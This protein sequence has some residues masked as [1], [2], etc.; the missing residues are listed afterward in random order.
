MR[1]TPIFTGKYNDILRIF[2]AFSLVNRRTLEKI[3]HSQ[4]KV[5]F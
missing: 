3:R 4:V 1:E 5:S 2:K